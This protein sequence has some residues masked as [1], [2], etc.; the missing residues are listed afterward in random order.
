MFS[1]E[2]MFRNDCSLSGFKMAKVINNEINQT[3]KEVIGVRVFGVHNMTSPDAN[4]FIDAYHCNPTRD[5]SGDIPCVGDI[6]YGMFLNNN[7]NI[8]VWFGWA[9]YNE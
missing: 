2:E 7:P 9:N 6:L 4:Y 1:V 5:E 8:F 3:N